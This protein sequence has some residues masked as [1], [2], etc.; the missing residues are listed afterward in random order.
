MAEIGEPIM[1]SGLSNNSSALR[2]LHFTLIRGQCY[3]QSRRFQVL[4]SVKLV[5]S[6]EG[7]FLSTDKSSTRE[8]G[9]T[10]QMFQK[11]LYSDTFLER[12]SAP[13]QDIKEVKNYDTSCI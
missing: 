13:F 12:R 2:Q 8:C 5:G 9:G 3:E 10:G 4:F 7:H 1:F 11:Y 6:S